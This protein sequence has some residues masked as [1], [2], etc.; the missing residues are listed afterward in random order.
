MG[1]LISGIVNSVV[2]F[3][4]KT[5]SYHDSCNFI[6][7]LSLIRTN[8]VVCITCV[9]QERINNDLRNDEKEY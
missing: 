6:D 5:A 2:I 4:K 3:I 8:A 1:S 7:L 9:L